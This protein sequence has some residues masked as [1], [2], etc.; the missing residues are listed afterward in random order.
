MF[1][2]FK[3]MSIILK[4][5]IYIYILYATVTDAMSFPLSSFD[6]NQELT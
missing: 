1:D 4:I 5:L 2:K 3:K 6:L